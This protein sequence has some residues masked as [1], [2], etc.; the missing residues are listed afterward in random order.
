MIDELARNTSISDATAASILEGMDKTQ[1]K[2]LAKNPV[3]FLSEAT[4][5]VR[6]VVEKELVRLVK[7]ETTGDMHPLDIFDAVIE[8]KRNTTHTPK[9]CLY[10]RIIHDSDIEQ[11]IAGDFDNEHAVRIFIKLPLGYKIPTPIGS[12]NPDFAL[13]IEKPNLETALSDDNTK[14]PRFYFTVETKGTS[15]KDKLKPDEQMKIDCAVKHFEAIG[16]AAYLAPVDSL[17]SFDQKALQH[18]DINQT[19]FDK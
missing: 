2:Q 5:K 14:A 1:H 7:Y 12:Y 17:K 9:R 18:P 10:D 11:S 16:L 13:V 4:Q 6:R 8:T 15:D 19:F 3:Q